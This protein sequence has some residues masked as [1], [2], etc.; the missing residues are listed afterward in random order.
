M[1]VPARSRPYYRICWSIPNENCARDTL[2]VRRDDGQPRIFG[3]G[4]AAASICGQ[5]VGKEESQSRR[6]SNGS[7]KARLLAEP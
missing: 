6:R 5:K 2:G 3:V 7:E 1:Q 4:S